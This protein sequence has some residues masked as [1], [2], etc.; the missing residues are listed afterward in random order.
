[1]SYVERRSC[2][3]LGEKQDQ[4]KEVSVNCDLLN[5]ILKHLVSTTF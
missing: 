3:Y 5:S 2:H 4:L 1:M